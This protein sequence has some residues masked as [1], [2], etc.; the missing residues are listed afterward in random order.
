MAKCRCVSDTVLTCTTWRGRVPEGF[1]Y[2]TIYCICMDEC[3]CS[4]GEF[5]YLFLLGEVYS[6]TVDT[7]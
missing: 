5:W 7:R 6:V 4:G 1:Y 2:S 3:L